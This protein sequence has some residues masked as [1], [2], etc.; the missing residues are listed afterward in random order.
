[1]GGGLTKSLFE[2]SDDSSSSSA[3]PRQSSNKRQELKD[4]VWKNFYKPGFLNNADGVKL[5]AGMLDDFYRNGISQDFKL[6][7]NLSKISNMLQTFKDDHQIMVQKLCDKYDAEFGVKQWFARLV[8]SQWDGS[9]ANYNSGNGGGGE[10][11]G[12]SEYAN[13]PGLSNVSCI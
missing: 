13:G 6:D 4:P 8:K 10:Y 5:T 9:G 3:T 1:M 7:K 2:S 12:M 11:H